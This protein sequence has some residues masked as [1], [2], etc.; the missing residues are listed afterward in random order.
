[1]DGHDKKILPRPETEVSFDLVKDRLQSI[2]GYMINPS[3]FFPAKVQTEGSC[4]E[5]F[6]S[7][8]FNQQPPVCS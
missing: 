4:T 8:T 7:G 5:Y 1:M 3:K 6:A 2:G